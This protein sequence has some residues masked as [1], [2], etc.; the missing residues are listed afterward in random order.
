MCIF[1]D[2]FFII[3]IISRI[4]QVCLRLPQSALCLHSSHGSLS[5]LSSPWL[6]KCFEYMPMITS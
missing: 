4:Q 3:K 1:V 5:Q 6:G 2:L